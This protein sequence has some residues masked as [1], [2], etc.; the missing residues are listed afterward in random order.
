MPGE[1]VGG[2]DDDQSTQEHVVV[3][4]ETLSSIAAQYDLH[5][6]SIVLA[7]PDLNG[8]LIHIG[9]ILRIPN[10][11][12]SDVELSKVTTQRQQKTVKTVSNKKT[13]Y[14]TVQAGSP[15]KA[16]NYVMPVN[17][18]GISRQ[19]SAG[20]PGAD[21]RAPIGTP[22]YAFTDGCII[23]RGPLGARSGGYGNVLLF[24][25]NDKV[26]SGLYA[27]LSSYAV[28]TE[29]GNCFSAGHVIG[30]VGITGNTTGPHLHFEIRLNGVKID[31]R[32]VI[33]GT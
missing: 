21:L 7:N 24:L 27:H 8:D 22:V 25:A 6:G 28:G 23:H 10:T 3:A 14:A 30:Y 5:S 20:H 4:G 19:F 32:R 18:T 11:D 13:T 31:P 26:T 17:P 9:D 15:T 12:A 16:G 33:P 2:S 1:I 29:E